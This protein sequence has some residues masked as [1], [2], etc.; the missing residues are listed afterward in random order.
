M[1]SQ[2]VRILNQLMAIHG[3]SLPMYLA[4]APPHR[5]FGD[6]RVWEC[7]SNVMA[8]Q[9]TMIDKLADYVEELGGTPNRGE[10]PMDFTGMHDLSME[11]ILQ[12]VTERQR[13]ENEWIEHLSAKL[14]DDPTAKAL[15]QEALGAAKQ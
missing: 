12:N 4:S 1:A 10:F 14:D 6:E 15:A 2:T 3:S 5:Q 7:L 9:Q 8:D 11:H 13:C